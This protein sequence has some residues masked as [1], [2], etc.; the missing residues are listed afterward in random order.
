MT[1][2]RLEFHPLTPDRWPDLQRLFG[3]RGACA[4]CWCMWWRLRRS[5]WEKNK[6]EGNKRAFRKLVRSGAEPGILAYADG[7]PIGWCAIAPREQ[8]PVLERSR[9]LKRI[10]DQ[11][12]WSVTCFFIARP[13]RGSGVSVKL[14]KAA[15]AFARRHRAK[16]VE[17]YPVESKTGRMPDAFAWTGFVSAFKKAGFS[18]VT[19]RSSSRPIM[20]FER[21]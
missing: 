21:S 12:V 8:Y 16:I 17:G 11:S 20:R 1:V 4:G 9:T 2:P 19:R 6:G 14:L 18:E 5:E 7:Q 15:V 10:D 13:F 3:V